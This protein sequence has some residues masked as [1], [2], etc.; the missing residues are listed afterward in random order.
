MSISK[1]VKTTD[2]FSSYSL[3]VNC[4]ISALAEDQRR[5]DAN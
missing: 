2:F 5:T 1:A 4:L 3:V